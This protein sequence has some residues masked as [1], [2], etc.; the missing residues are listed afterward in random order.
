MEGLELKILVV[1][2]SY[3]RNRLTLV[4]KYYFHKWILEYQLQR[5][6]NVCHVSACLMVFVSFLPPQS[7]VVDATRNPA[8]RFDV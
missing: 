1:V 5:S 7:Q 6:S 8:E 3:E 2:K 4:E